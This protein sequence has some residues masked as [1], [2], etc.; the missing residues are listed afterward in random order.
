MHANNDSSPMMVSAAALLGLGLL[1]GC[2][3][4]DASSSASGGAQSATGGTRNAAGSGGGSS[5]ATGGG[6]SS[7]SGPSVCDSKAIVTAPLIANFDSCTVGLTGDAVASGCQLASIG[8]STLFGGV[9]SYDDGT[10]NPTFS[11]VPGHASGGLGLATTEP[12]SKYG[13]GFGVWTT[14]CFNASAYKGISFW[15]RGIVPKDGK[16]TFS[17]MMA[18]TAP[19]VPPAGTTNRGTCTGASEQC[20]S[21]KF[22]FPVTDTWTQVHAPWSGFM[23]GDA[24][25]TPVAANGDDIFQFQWEIGLAFAPDSTGSYVAQPAEYELEIDDVAFE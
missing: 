22:S 2:T 13:G 3:T 10:G 9:F 19:S 8:G 24:N 1:A 4:D 21:P 17:V 11:V 16:A 5:A 12:A 18:E 14:G 6:G 25:G 7:S 23:G 20:K 15:A